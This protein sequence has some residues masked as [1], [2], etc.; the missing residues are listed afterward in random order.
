[1]INQKKFLFLLQFRQGMIIL[2][3]WLSV[4]NVICFSLF[5]TCARL[6]SLSKNVV[7]LE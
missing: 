6:K 7:R 5:K 3:Y 4:N 2:F 1:M